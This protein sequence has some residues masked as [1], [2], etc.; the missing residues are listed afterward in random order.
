MAD[1]DTMTICHAAT[2]LDN[3]DIIGL[4]VA[5][6]GESFV[7]SLVLQKNFPDGDE[8]ELAEEQRLI[9]DFAMIS[10]DHFVMVDGVGKVFEVNGRQTTQTA[11][12][13]TIFTGI[14]RAADG[15]L[16]AYGFKGRVF[17][18][19]GSDW[20]ALPPLKGD[21][22]CVRPASGPILYACGLG[23]LFARFDGAAWSRLEIGTNADLQS[24]LVW[25][26]GRVLVCG[27]SGFAGLW[28]DETWTRWEVPEFD[29][30]DL[31]S[32]KG[33]IYVGAGSDGLGIVE[34]ST[35]RILKENIFSYTLRPN[36]KYLAIAGNNE[37]ARFDGKDYPYL[38]YN[39]D[40]EDG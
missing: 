26:D 9:A 18:S 24:L 23:G 14:Y 27:L 6:D 8:V 11:D 21:V 28:S 22:L 19:T 37:V 5:T 29:Y 30:Y 25:D 15:R 39:Y 34:R 13:E 10:P 17:A 38:E 33:K 35:F 16:F 20:S 12:L 40:L 3:G 1:D 31:A 2:P 36:E 32:F 4:I 7:S